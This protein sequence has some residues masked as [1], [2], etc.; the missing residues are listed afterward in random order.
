[1]CTGFGWDS[2]G[3][4]LAVVAEKSS[5]IF[6]WDANNWRQSQL[7]S[8]FRYAALLSAYF[9]GLSMGNSNFKLQLSFLWYSG[10]Q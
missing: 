6:L 8:G 9:V 10:D 2:E 7:D 1:M 3:D 5:V 4:V